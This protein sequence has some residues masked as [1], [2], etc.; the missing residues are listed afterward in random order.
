MIGPARV[1][2]LALVAAGAGVVA[3][4]VSRPTLGREPPPAE[5]LRRLQQ[6]ADALRRQAE[7]IRTLA[8]KSPF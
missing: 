2:G 1:L 3:Y 5:D 8:A 6:A 4:A 7:K